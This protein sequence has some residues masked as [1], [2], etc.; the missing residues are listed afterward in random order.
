[1]EV[2]EAIK[3]IVKHASKGKTAA[4]VHT[5][6]RAFPRVGDEPAR[7]FIAGADLG[8]WVEVG[9]DLP[10][11]VYDA[12]AL[13]AVTDTVQ[14]VTSEVGGVDTFHTSQ[15]GHYTL[16]GGPSAGYPVPPDAPTDWRAVRWSEVQ[17]LLTSA[18]KKGHSHPE[19]QCVKF[20]ETHVEAT[21]GFRVGLVDE[22]VGEGAPLG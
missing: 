13:S 5:Q 20:T 8:V 1:M 7:L 3:R 12:K 10:D 16:V 22:A 9:V 6:V 14:R 15:G 2:T 21:D 19:V 18:G 17:R 4:T 11:R